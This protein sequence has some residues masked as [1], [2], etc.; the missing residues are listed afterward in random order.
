MKLLTCLLC[1]L[2]ASS[3]ATADSRYAGNPNQPYPP[4]CVTL[5]GPFSPLTNYGELAQ[6]LD[7]TVDLLKSESAERVA[8]ELRGFR[9]TCSEPNRSMIWLQFVVPESLADDDDQ[10]VELPQAVIELPSGKRIPMN[11]ADQP[12]L[13]GAN[14]EVD[15]SRKYLGPSKNSNTNYFFQGSDFILD[16]FSPL[17][18]SASEIT[19]TEYNSNFTLVLRYPPDDLASYVVPSLQDSYPY[20]NDL[21]DLPLSGR[22]SGLW[23][24]AGAEDQGFSIAVSSMPE[25]PG[26]GPP[27]PLAFPANNPEEHVES[28]VV[29]LAHFTF[30]ANG[31]PLWLTG[32]A[33]FPHDNI[34]SQSVATA[35][36]PMLKV[37]QGEFLGNKS[38]VRENAGS[39]GIMRIADCNSIWIEYD[40]RNLGLG[41]ATVRL[42]RKFSLETA[43]YEC[44]DYAARVAAV[45]D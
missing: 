24:V 16:S 21:G 17:S 3:T 4:A 43:G 18:E 29:F 5:P 39:I 19:A 38:A 8:V 1:V 42:Q 20:G 35:T 14:N 11:L 22:L 36:I 28:L 40:Y 25:A 9:L 33:R 12:H 31:R 27:N 44:R 13:W 26:S 7:T 2:L 45:S 30:D 15:R 6:F 32:A 34:D 10:A 37:N 23:V 41:K